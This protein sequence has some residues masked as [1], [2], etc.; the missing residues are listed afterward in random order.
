MPRCDVRGTQRHAIYIDGLG[1]A[2]DVIGKFPFPQVKPPS[3]SSTGEGQLPS[4]NELANYAVVVTTYERCRCEHVRLASDRSWAVGR[5]DTGG[6]RY[7][8]SPLM[9]LRWLRLVCDEGH[10]LG[11][12]DEVTRTIVAGT[13]GCILPRV[14]AT[15]L[16]TG[17]RQRAP[18]RL[19]DRRREPLGHDRHANHRQR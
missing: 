4:H 15:I 5:A 3:A 9:K 10:E 14:P 13:L 7:A 8:E 12:A 19:R 2:D 17:G 18:V 11:G 6:D 16:R 1:D